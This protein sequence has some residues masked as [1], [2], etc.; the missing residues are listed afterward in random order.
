M[1]NIKNYYEMF[2]GGKSLEL[3]KKEITERDL[4]ILREKERI[5]FFSMIENDPS[6]PLIALVGLCPGY[7][8]VSKL[9]SDYNEFGDFLKAKENASF[10]KINKNI[11]LMLRKIGLDKYLEVNLIDYFDYN[12]SPSFFTTS[13]VK[14]ASLKEGKGRS[15]E[16]NPLKFEFAMK[17]IRGRFVEDILSR[18]SLKKIVFFGKKNEFIVNEKLIEGKSIREILEEEGKEIIFLPHPSG[19][20]NGGVARFLRK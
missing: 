7:N 3:D 14:C 8:Q 1:I 20:N 9:I 16:F 19:S 10:S 2:C 12:N 15:D 11:S 6:E 18:P 17:C 5:L 4:I 13:L